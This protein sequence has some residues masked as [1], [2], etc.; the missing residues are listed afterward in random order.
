VADSWSEVDLFSPFLQLLLLSFL[1][2][3]VI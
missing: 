1:S 2:L 3:A